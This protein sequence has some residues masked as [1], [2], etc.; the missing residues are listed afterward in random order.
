[1]PK[2]FWD[3][4]AFT[5]SMPK[6]SAEVTVSEVMSRAVVTIEETMTIQQAADVMKSH[7]IRGLVVCKN[8]V[9]KGILTDR[10]IVEKVVAKNKSGKTKVES[11]MTLKDNLIT[12]RPEEDLLTVSKRMR[13]TGVGRIPVV[14]ES[15][16]LLGIVTETDLTRVYPGLVEVLYEE[17]DMKRT[18]YPEK[19][20]MA[21]RCDICGNYSEF[22]VREGEEW[23][24]DEC[25]AEYMKEKAKQ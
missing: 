12:A 6:K 23:I 19:E 25:G 2:K 5:K 18:L 11:V 22:L 4:F 24:C 1:M 9:V 16:K 3:H 10:D 20:S 21:G 14:G 7:G 13:V 8:N 17:L 15:G